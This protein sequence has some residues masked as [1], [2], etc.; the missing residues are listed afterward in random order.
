MR[1]QETDSAGDTKDSAVRLSHGVAGRRSAVRPSRGVARRRGAWLAGAAA[2]GCAAL[3]LLGGVFAL[4]GADSGLFH[5]ADTDQNRRISMSELLRVVQFFNANGYEPRPGTEDGFAPVW[6]L[7]DITPPPAR[8]FVPDLIGA[9]R[10]QAPALLAAAALVIGEMREEH[11]PALAAGHVIE[12]DPPAGR[13]VDAGTAVDVVVSL[14][15]TEFF[16]P[17]GLL[18]T[19]TDDPLTTMTIDWHTADAPDAAPVLWFRESGSVVWTEHAG[20]RFPFPFSERTVHRAALSGLKPGTEYAFRFGSRSRVFRFRTMPADLSAPLRFAAGGDTRH[21]QE[22]MERTNRV[23]MA[24]D[25][26]FVVWGGD[27]AYADGK[28]EN[29][30]RWYEWFDA[31][32]NTL[33]DE[34]GRVVPVVAAIGNH[35][36]RGGYYVNHANYADTDAWRASVAP[37]FYTL[38]AFP[39]QP[40]YRTLD[41]GDY[42]SFIVL[43]TDHTNPVDGPQTGWLEEALSERVDVPHVFPVYHVPAYPSNRAFSGTISTRVRTHWVPLFEDYGVRAAFEHHDH[44]YKRTHAILG[45]QVHPSGVVYFGDGAWG[46]NT[47]TVHAVNGTWYLAQAASKRHAIIVTLHGQHQQFLVVDEDGEILDQYP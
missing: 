43:D 45:G 18:L 28:P 29:L 38:F 21:S 5:S 12:H 19:W 23:A 10:D 7:P 36:V 20:E 1:G 11:H 35:E 47:R 14:G 37:Y 41:F 27:L 24:H 39:G 34:D 4:A 46:V 9:P 33:I 16:D 2:G 13:Y 17:P 44:T 15:T 8:V 3:M 32:K 31:L 22:M 40:G 25:P 26:E 42:L 30:Y 6:S